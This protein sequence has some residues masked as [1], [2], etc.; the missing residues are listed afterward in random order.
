VNTLQSLDG[1]QDR[2]HFHSAFKIAVSFRKMLKI[3]LQFG[4][5]AGWKFALLAYAIR[6]NDTQGLCKRNVRDPTQG[7]IRQEGAQGV[8][9]ETVRKASLTPIH[10]RHRMLH[11]VGNNDTARCRI[12]IARSLASQRQQVKC[13]GL[14]RVDTNSLALRPCLGFFAAQGPAR[15][16]LTVACVEPDA[17][18]CSRGI[19]F[20]I[21]VEERQSANEPFPNCCRA[22]YKEVATSLC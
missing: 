11:V 9:R 19:A 10:F 1:I 8:H 13:R 3:I 20:F 15:Q 21:A 6:G 5:L 7:R 17:R 2:I 4:F 12:L 14:G 22:I 16:C 18:C